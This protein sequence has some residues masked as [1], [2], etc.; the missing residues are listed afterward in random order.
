M[1]HVFERGILAAIYFDKSRRH[2]WTI[3]VSLTIVRIENLKT[4]ASP[5]WKWWVQDSSRWVTRISVKIRGHWD[6]YMFYSHI[7]KY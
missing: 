2:F 4:L 3:L 7:S 1:P 6:N 5:T